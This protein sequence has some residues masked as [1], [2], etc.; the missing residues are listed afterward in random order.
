MATNILDRLLVRLEDTKRR[1]GEVAPAHLEK[2]LVRIGRQQFPNA[3]SLARFHDAVLFLRAHPPNQGILRR[4]ESL[5]ASFASRVDEF[6]KSGGDLSPLDDEEVSGIAGTTLS[7]DFHYDQVCWLVK[8]FPR[9]VSIDW[10]GY[11]KNDALG[12]TLPRLIPLLEDDSLVE[13]DVPY[14]RWM[15]AAS[16]GSGRVLLW[17]IGQ[18]QKLS[19]SVEEQAE[20]FG[21]LEL[22][23]RWE[24]G[25]SRATRTH[26]K[27][28]VREIFYQR[29]P[30]LR[31]SQVSLSQELAKP[32]LKLKKLSLR[33]GERILDLCRE[34]TTVRYRELYGTTRGDPSSVLQADVGRGVQIFLWGLPPERRLPLRA[35]QAGFTL[36]NGVPINYI[37]GISLFEWMEIGFNTFYAYREGETAWI[38]A[39]ALRMLRQILGVSCIS[40]YP[41]QIG[42]D[43]EEAI[44]SGAFW[45]Y[46]KLGFRPMREELAKLA[47]EEEK[48]IAANPGYRTPARTLRRLA[49]GHVVYELPEA[50]R[51]EWDRFRMR[52]VGLAVPQQMAKHFAGDAS[53][54]RR[55]SAQKLARLLPM[56]P[57]S[58][59]T[60]EQKAFANFALVLEM[61]PDVVH[62]TA[63]E[64][65]LLVGIIRA[66]AKGSEPQYSHLLQ[67][68][69][70]LRAAILKLGNCLER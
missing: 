37:E 55:A 25:N 45:F 35:Y 68:H 63:A 42:Q 33:Q 28:P 66:K 1:V 32:P 27:F 61:I 50:L 44:Q 15:E 19:L 34:A 21:S 8:K 65:D 36:K 43:N 14:R 41:Y 18:F 16:G 53:S 58:W 57:R 13:P 2:L 40:V 46:R 69:P 67:A 20:I 7:A 54:F 48:K 10:E 29:E 59:S 52:N 47:E 23:V 5:L 6:R 56:R 11:E 24:L 51:S 49:Q 30:L 64:K 70:R 12:A 17:L 38:Y 39:Q 9:T 31:R 60:L 26:G 62:W 22:P 4:V 3:Q